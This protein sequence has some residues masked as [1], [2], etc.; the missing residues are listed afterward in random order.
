MRIHL[1][2]KKLTILSLL[3]YAL[4]VVATTDSHEKMARELV[5]EMEAH[6]TAKNHLYSKLTNSK[7]SFSK[8]ERECL[9]SKLTDEFF[10]DF[11]QNTYA[12]SYSENEMKYMLYIYRS[13]LGKLTKS[14]AGKDFSI[15]DFMS[16]FNEYDLEKLN[17]IFNPDRRIRLNNLQGIK[18]KEKIVRI[19]RKH[20]KTNEC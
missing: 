5:I 14:H 18:L 7:S 15:A 17:N 3:F 19:I 9:I 10:L 16:E 6:T 11:F 13:D 12:E 2:I 1:L 4:A 20:R 8:D